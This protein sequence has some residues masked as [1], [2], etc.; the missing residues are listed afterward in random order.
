MLAKMLDFHN[1]AVKELFDRLNLSYEHYL[2]KNSVK[3]D[4]AFFLNKVYEELG[5]LS[6][7]FLGT[8]EQH[9]KLSL[10]ASKKMIEEEAADVLCQIIIFIKRNNISVERVIE[11]KWLNDI[12]D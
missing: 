9:P 7:A 1:L 8:Q 12:S 2:I 10:T 6:R 5:E 3:V 4:D 11:S